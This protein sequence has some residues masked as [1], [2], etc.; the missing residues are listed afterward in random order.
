MACSYPNLR[1]SSS[2]EWV[3]WVFSPALGENANA[4]GDLRHPE[5]MYYGQADEK[6]GGGEDRPCGGA[7]D[8]PDCLTKEPILE[9]PSATSSPLD[10]VGNSPAIDTDSENGRS[11]VSERDRRRKVFWGCHVAW[12][13]A[14]WGRF[15]ASDGSAFAR[16]IERRSNT[17]T[18]VVYTWLLWKCP[19]T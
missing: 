4:A 19:S 8:C 15:A 14:T 2:W 16:R 10:Q 11:K 1:P 17:G 12:V 7:A 18:L 3:V 9:S 6:I 13:F 5:E